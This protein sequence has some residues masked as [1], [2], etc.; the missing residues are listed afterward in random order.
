MPEHED[1]KTLR[2]QFAAAALPAMA[3]AYRPGETSMR[4]L[5][6]QLARAAYALADAMLKERG[7]DKSK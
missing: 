4:D 3:G 5:A 6:D 1:E 7:K 2:D